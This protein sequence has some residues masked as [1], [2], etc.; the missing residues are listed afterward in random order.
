M[1]YCSTQ[2]KSFL[3]MR[4]LQ[5][6][7]SHYDTGFIFQLTV[8]SKKSWRGFTCPTS[9]A[10]VQECMQVLWS[11][12]QET[13]KREK[14]PRCVCVCL[15][16]GVCGCVWCTEQAAR[17]KSRVDFTGLQNTGRMR[18]PLR[19][20]G[21]DWKAPSPRENRNAS[22]VFQTWPSEPLRPCCGTGWAWPCPRGS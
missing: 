2:K 14:K 17:K 11:A 10:D 9:L 13:R 18:H 21:S 4:I 8:I 22:L 6:C 16:V 5:T 7:F 12:L 15:C 1:S 3:G 19:L 20:S